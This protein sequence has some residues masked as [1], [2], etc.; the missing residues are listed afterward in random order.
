I[1]M[2]FTNRG[3]SLLEVLFFTNC[4]PGPEPF[5]IN[6]FGLAWDETIIEVGDEGR[7]YL[8]DNHCVSG[9]TLIT[10]QN[11]PNL[12]DITYFPNPYA[13]NIIV[14]DNG[15]LIRLTPDLQLAGLNNPA[16]IYNL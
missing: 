10:V 6:S 8:S 1:V 11:E 16:G 13:G 4:S 7:I 14:G 3:C 9:Y 12:N 5:T 15:T 2:G